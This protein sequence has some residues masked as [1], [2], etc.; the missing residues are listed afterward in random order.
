VRR[1]SGCLAP[2]LVEEAEV[3]QGEGQC[4]RTRQLPGPCRGL[5]AAIR[6][7]VGV[8]KAM[9]GVGQEEVAPYAEV[10]RVGVG[11]RAV[12]RGIIE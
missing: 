1:E 2:A 8:A 6:S 3:V 9:Q 12:L 5:A 4:D 11:E 7:L 10:D